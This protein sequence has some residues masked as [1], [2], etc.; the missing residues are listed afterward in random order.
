VSIETEGAE[1]KAT[2]NSQ[3]W[4]APQVQAITTLVA[5]IMTTHGIEQKLA[6]DAKPGPSSRGLSWHRLGIDGNFPELPSPLAGRKQRGG[7]MHYSESFGKACP[8]DAKILQIPGILAAIT[9][10]GPAV[11]VPPPPAG[12]LDVDGFWGSATTTRAQVVLGVLPADGQVRF[13]F[14]PNKQDAMTSGWVFDFVPGRGSPLIT[15]MQEI[16]AAAGQY[17][18]TV[19]GVAGPEFSRGLQRRFGTVVDGT[20]QAR[21]PTV[22]ALQSALNA[23]AF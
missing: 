7:G 2:V 16:M 18:S 6:T 17:Q 23:G 14:K 8:G 9:G 20:L 22:M 13:Q 11:V 21:S 4:T 1:D 5:W 12:A 19:D 15:R 3:E 10:G